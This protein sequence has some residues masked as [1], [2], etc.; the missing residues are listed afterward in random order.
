MSNERYC[1]FL[2]C[3]AVLSQSTMV[4]LHALSEYLINKPPANVLSLD[5]DIRIPGRK[6]IRYH[7][8]PDTA[9]AARSSRVRT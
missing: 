3:F 8:N 6:E 1:S 7:F 5:V 9:Y 4:V 2:F